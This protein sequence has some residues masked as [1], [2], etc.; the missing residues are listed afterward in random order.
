MIAR[1][2]SII[3]VDY[4]RCGSPPA[5]VLDRIDVSPLTLHRP[6]KNF[7][8]FEPVRGLDGGSRVSR[9]VTTC[10][11]G[12]PGLRPFR[13]SHRLSIK[14]CNHISSHM[15]G[16]PSFRC[17]V[18]KGVDAIRVLIVDPTLMNAHPLA[19]AVYHS[20]HVCLCGCPFVPLAASWPPEV[21][22]PPKKL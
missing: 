16:S 15:S 22:T 14:R 9:F 8:V 12:V 2:V 4:L 3:S 11:N 19:T 20:Y 7:L 6:F 17:C 21:A 13:Y 18:D 5:A 1:L 10:L